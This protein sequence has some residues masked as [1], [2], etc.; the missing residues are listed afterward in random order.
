MGQ[1]KDYYAFISYKREDEKWAKWLQYKLE[2]YRFPINI[3]GRSDL[4]KYIRPTFR[5]VT[6]LTPGLLA[7]EIGNALRSSEWLIIVC[8]P[9]S[10]KSPWVCKEAQTFID[11]GRSDHIIPFVIEGNPFSIEANTECYPNALLNLTGSQELLAANVNEMGRDAAAIKVVA[12]MFNL[13]FDTLWQRYERDQRRKMR[14]ILSGVFLLLIIASC[15]AYWMWSKNIALLENKARYVSEKILEHAKTDSYTS[16][17]M[18][19]SIQEPDYPYTAEAEGALRSCLLYNSAIIN[20]PTKAIT[21]AEFS[22]DNQRIASVSE[23][24]D[25]SIWDANSG[26]LL[27]NLSNLSVT[28]EV[29]YSRNSKLFALVTQNNDV[30]VWNA[31]DGRLE[32]TLGRTSEP[33]TNLQ[34]NTKGDGVIGTLRDSIFF[35]NIKTKQITKTIKT[36]NEIQSVRLGTDDKTL[37]IIASNM[38]QLYDIKEDKKKKEIDLNGKEEFDNCLLSPNNKYIAVIDG[39]SIKI[40]STEDGEQI[41]SLKGHENHI[42]SI[43]FCSNSNLVISGSYAVINIWD[44]KSGS[45]V[46]SLE[47]HTN[48]VTSVSFSKDNKRILSSSEDRTIRLWDYDKETAQKVLVDKSGFV[49]RAQFIPNST[50]VVSSS[51]KD[52]IKIWDLENNMV[53]REIVEGHG[54]IIDH[55]QISPNGKLLATVA[56]DHK[57]RFW[58]IGN[59]TLQNT[60]ENSSD[61]LKPIAYSPNGKYIASIWKEK[62][63]KLWNVDNGKFFCL[64]KGHSDAVS[65]VAFSPDGQQIAS[66]S[67]DGTIKIWNANNGNTLFTLSGDFGAFEYITFSPDGKFLAAV[68]DGEISSGCSIKIWNLSNRKIEHTLYGHNDGIR[69]ITYSPNGKYLLSTSVDNTARIWDIKS[70]TLLMSLY[71]DDIVNY[72][73]FSPDGNKIMTSCYDGRI[74]IWN[75]PPLQNIIE[76]TKARFKN[77]KSTYDERRKFYLE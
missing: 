7:K 31:N 65:F 21:S 18:A 33:I 15:I 45:L 19:I 22:P 72:A 37:V 67:N 36:N 20:S 34:F 47:G 74:R 62:T 38:I 4:P 44:I 27:Y 68:S 71:H 61:M 12:R 9:R 66:A 29:A 6:D 59:G 58:N 10:A 63:I 5:D 41:S 55:F 60:L 1:N 3:N 51:E 53:V 50:G 69:S 35:W 57:I 23:E 48:Y 42:T 56:L 70:E 14:F 28:G 77:R 30:K 16:Q 76:K 75:F 17:I 39:L 2:H 13:K 8:S 11:I 24:G 40:F 54:E 46:K 43:G 25:V 64:L 26:A 32:C 49:W 73:E 52:T